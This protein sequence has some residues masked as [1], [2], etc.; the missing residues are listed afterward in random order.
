MVKLLLN[1]G[2]RDLVMLR[3]NCGESCLFK[4]AAY[5]H[6]VIVVE[7]LIGVGGREFI[8]MEN[9]KGYSITACIWLRGAGISRWS[10][11]L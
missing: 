6:V 7:L 5:G 2:G 11:L 8:L 9:V 4:A 3:K 1:F 10:R